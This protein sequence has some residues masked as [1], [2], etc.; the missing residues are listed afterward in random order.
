MIIEK[1]EAYNKLEEVFYDL[2]LTIEE[3][4][5]MCREVNKSCVFLFTTML[6]VIK[7]VMC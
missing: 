1:P 2:G 6:N 4:I 7:V 5:I 3:M